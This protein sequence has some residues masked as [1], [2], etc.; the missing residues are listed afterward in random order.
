[1]RI[2]RFTTL[3]GFV[4]TFLS[5]LPGYASAG[6]VHAAV[7]ANFTKPM[8]ELAARFEAG[9]GHKVTLSAGSTGKLYAQIRNGAPFDLFFSAD[10][11]YPARLE[12]E[13]QAVAGSC[14]TYA[15]GRLALW[16]PREGYVDGE[17]RVLQ[18]G[19]FQRLA[20][21]NPKTAPYGAAARQVLEGMGLWAEVSPRL[22]QGENI[23]QTHQFIASGNAELGFIALSQTKDDARMGGSLWIV[24]QALYS[25]IEQQAALLAKGRDN[26]AAQALLD[27]VKSDEARTIIERYGYGLN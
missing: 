12:R 22:V 8:K 23:S 27:F 10:K 21:A 13:G 5:V 25:P 20:I 9:T 19:G 18:Q 15:I 6:E 11:E 26:P 2:K 1:M 17:G 4:L 3:F 14:F 24:P 7:A 16:S